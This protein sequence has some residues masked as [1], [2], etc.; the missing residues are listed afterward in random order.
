MVTETTSTR[1]VGIISTERMRQTAIAAI[2]GGVLLVSYT[3]ASVAFGV[4][5]NTRDEATVGLL[6]ALGALLVVGG[7]YGVHETVKSEYGR[8]ATGIAGLLGLGLVGMAVGL[9]TNFAFPD[10]RSDDATLGG[11][12]WFLSLLVTYLA[13]TAYGLVLWRTGAVSRTG[14]ALL[15]STVPA[16]VVALVGAEVL[17]VG[18]VDVFGLLWFV[19]FGLAWIVVG[20]DLRTRAVATRESRT[21][22]AA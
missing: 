11:T 20:N 10:V 14:A 21:T 4:E 15:A 22:P 2:V 1:Q 18:G 13:A 19:P 8:L 9:T 17:V 7:L 3:V 5:A 6:Y 12:I 16:L